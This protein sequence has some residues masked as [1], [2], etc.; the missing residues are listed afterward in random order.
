MAAAKAF[1]DA[2]ARKLDP[3]T[4]PMKHPDALI[5]LLTGSGN[6]TS[7][8]T[9]EPFSS[10]ELESSDVHTVLNSFD[11]Y[12]GP[13]TA[14]VVVG[15]ERFHKANPVLYKAFLGALEEATNL[16]NRDR[17]QAAQIYIDMSGDKSLPKERLMAIL[18]NPQFRYTLTPENIMQTATFMAGMGVVK[19]K[20]TSWKDMFFSDIHGLSGS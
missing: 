2:N 17:D 15:T 18:S 5:G 11:I 6:V 16:I 12:G 13:A 14:V 19:S 7:H 10:R 8:F 4:V 9:N 3:M 20:P 1:G